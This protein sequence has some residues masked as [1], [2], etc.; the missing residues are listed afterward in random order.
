MRWL[1]LVMSLCEHLTVLDFGRV[2]ATGSPSKIRNDPAV[3]AAYLG[4]ESSAAQSPV[5]ETAP[6]A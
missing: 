3:I 5:P 6:R 4:T 1:D 2:I